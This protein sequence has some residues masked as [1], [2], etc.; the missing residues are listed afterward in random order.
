MSEEIAAADSL[1]NMIEPMRKVLD[2][3]RTFRRAYLICEYAA[4]LGESVDLY[5]AVDQAQAAL[6]QA[7]EAIDGPMV[8]D[9]P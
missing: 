8:Y 7:I 6:F 3:A 9:K 4:T 1:L 5:E 2:A